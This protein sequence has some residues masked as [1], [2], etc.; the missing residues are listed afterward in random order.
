MYT[1]ELE[2]RL[3][4]LEAELRN[5]RYWT[6]YWKRKALHY[7]Q[8]YYNIVGAPEAAERDDHDA[9]YDGIKCED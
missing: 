2:G 4:G 1:G 7:Q 8:L 5:Q 6:E 9:K 3:A